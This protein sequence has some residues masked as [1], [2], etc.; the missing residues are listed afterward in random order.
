[1]KFFLRLIR[2]GLLTVFILGVLGAGAV[3][4]A[5]LYVAP[6][7]PS[8]E[9]LKDVQLQVPLR[10]YSREGELI[11]EYGEMRRTPLDY[12]QIPTAMVQAVLAAEDDRFFEHPGVDYQGIIRAVVHLIRT[13]SKGQGGSTITMQVA[14][15]FFLS[16]EKTYLRKVREI[17]LALTIE[18]QLTKPEILELYLNKIYLGKRSYGVAAAAQVYYGKEINELGVP[19]LAMIA[20]LPKA[21]SRFNPV[22]N[23]ERAMERRDY[24]LRRMHELDFISRDEY[25]EYLQTPAIAHLHASSNQ[26]EAPFL[27]EMVRAEMVKHFGPAAYTAG[28]R[29]YTTVEARLQTGANQALREALLEYH[30]RHGYRGP[31]AHVVLEQDAG[32][33]AWKAALKDRSSIGNLQPGIVVDVGET[34]AKVYLRGEEEPVELDWEAM[35]WARPYIDD[36]RVGPEPKKAADILNVGDIVRLEPAGEE[37]WLLAEVPEVSGALVSL[38]PDDGAV[39]SVVGGFDYYQSKFNRAIQAE[40]QPGSNF[41][42]F[43]YSAALANGFTPA[44][45]INDAPVV[46]ADQA[47]ETE[48][49]PQNY[50]G[51]FFGPTRLREALVRS[52]NL[53]SIRLLRSMGVPSALDHVAKFGFDPKSLNRD[54]SMALG[55][56]AMTPWVLARGYAVL[57]NGGF[58]VKPYFIQ[59]IEDAKGNLLF[60]ADPARACL[61]CEQEG[62]EEAEQPPE[63][64][65]EPKVFVTA[66]D[67]LADFLREPHL[68]PRSVDL[69][70]VYLVTSM[71]Q[72]VIRRGTGQ[73]ALTLGRRDLAGKTGTTNEQLDAW[74]S[75]FNRDVVTTTW[76][77][78]DTPRSMGRYETGSRA[79]LPMWIKYMAV[80]LDGRSEH[81]LE[82]PPGLV[83]VRIDPETGLLARS[84]TP[85]AMF[86]TFR[87]EYVP[88]QKTEPVATGTETSGGGSTVTEQ[89]F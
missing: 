64:E 39:L 31:E 13:G 77:G 40:R 44:S 63:P 5:Y 1:M 55:S 79:A 82:Q 3:V 68:A 12:E 73:K 48:W 23:P 52:R 67:P 32:P 74:F 26:M 87:S 15:N 56:S 18:R 72:D 21:P 58:Q 70:N 16:S 8:I 49:R 83:S 33:E 65:I 38:R 4:G 80:A 47:L 78:F 28:Y 25:E 24:V 84:G 42:P 76:V 88:E 37:Q 27:A 53:V 36:F 57:A 7:L 14:R 29:V 60:K 69:R 50:S 81:K 89:L 34:S 51:R 59:R 19:E 6:E 46:F 10:I 86:E 22:V 66:T 45:V 61:P 85:D 41:K 75:G 71:L 54:L 30:R 2:R 20:G 35:A 9:K 11:A 62:E 17:F 43:I